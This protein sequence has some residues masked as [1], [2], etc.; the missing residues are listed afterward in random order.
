MDKRN[1]STNVIMRLDKETLR[2][3]QNPQEENMKEIWKGFVFDKNKKSCYGLNDCVPPKFICWIL[4]L[5]EMALRGGSFGR[6]LGHKPE[7][8]WMASVH[9]LVML[10]SSEET[11]VYRPGPGIGWGLYLGHCNHQNCEKSM[12][13]V[14]RYPIY[15][16]FVIAAGMG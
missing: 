11:A 1:L 16:M 12:V 6:W 14:K 13:V 3:R 7:P 4:I 8:S 2:T 15:S 10:A 9:S 5:K